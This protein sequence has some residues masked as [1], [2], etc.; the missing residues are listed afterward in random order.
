MDPQSS[1]GKQY[2]LKISREFNLKVNKKFDFRENL[3]EN[4]S[5]YFLTHKKMI[6]IDHVKTVLLEKFADFNGRASRAEFWYFVLF[7]VILGFVLGLILGRYAMI[8]SNIINLILLVPSLAVGARRL[9][10]IG[11]SGWMQLWWLLPIAG[12]IYMIIL[13]ATA[14]KPEKNEYGEAPKK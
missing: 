11:K 10:D 8:V 9:H 14:G 6:M 2:F 13:L 4:L 5:V 12:W 1:W 7:T 3:A